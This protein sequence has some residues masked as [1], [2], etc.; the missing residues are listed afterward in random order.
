MRKAT[1]LIGKE[2][3]NQETA[4]KIATIQDIIL[5]KQA[6]HIVAL[7]IDSGGWFRDAKVVHW[8]NVVSIGDVVVM[9]GETPAITASDD[10]QIALLMEEKTTMTGTTIISASG[11]KIG[12]VTDLYIDD[13]GVVTGYEVSQGFL[14]NL[15]GRKFLSAEHISAVGK[16]A[17]IASDADLVPAKEVLHPREDRHDT[18]DQPAVQNHAVK[19][20]EPV[21]TE[22]TVVYDRP[23]TDESQTR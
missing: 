15:G 8:R 16:D 7:L 5:D 11:E 22:R 3:V 19:D 23:E 12:S 4:E 14:S 18:D 9:R 2:L 10:P 21:V 20:D 13:N 6:R 1:E 17:I